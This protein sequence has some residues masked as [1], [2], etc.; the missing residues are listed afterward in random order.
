MRQVKLLG[1]QSLSQAV[2]QPVSQSVC[3]LV[4]QAVSQSV[5]LSVSQ[6][7]S[8][9]LVISC[10]LLD[11]DRLRRDLS[12]FVYN[13]IFNGACIKQERM[14]DSPQVT[15]NRLAN[16][17][18]KVSV[19]EPQLACKESAEWMW[20]FDEQMSLRYS[21]EYPELEGFLPKQEDRPANTMKNRDEDS[22]PG[23]VTTNKDEVNDTA[24]STV[25]R[26]KK[27]LPRKLQRT[28][29]LSVTG[30]SVVTVE[31]RIE[32]PNTDQVDEPPSQSQD[33]CHGED[34][35]EPWAS[36]S[37]AAT[38]IASPVV[39][40]SIVEAD[41]TSS[42]SDRDQNSVL[43][44]FRTA[45]GLAVT[46]QDVS[47]LPSKESDAEIS[48]ADDTS[49]RPENTLNAL[50][51]MCSKAEGSWGD[52]SYV[53]WSHQEREMLSTLSS[54][55]Q[56]PPSG[57]FAQA[58]L[59]S[60]CNS[61]SSQDEQ[62]SETPR[63]S[64]SADL[65]VQLSGADDGSVVTRVSEVEARTHT[66][67]PPMSSTT[68]E[69]VTSFARHSSTSLSVTTATFTAASGSSKML[70]KNFLSDKGPTTTDR[71]PTNSTAAASGNVSAKT[72]LPVDSISNHTNKF[73]GGQLPGNKHTA[74]R[75]IVPAPNQSLDSVITTPA[76]NAS[77]E[78]GYYNDTTPYPII[79]DTFSMTENIPSALAQQG[80]SEIRYSDSH[81]TPSRNTPPPQVNLAYYASPNPYQ[82][83]QTGHSGFI[84]LDSTVA[85]Q[86]ISLEK[87]Y[88]FSLP[89]YQDYE[90]CR[91]RFYGSRY[92]KTT[93]TN[94]SRLSLEPLCS[95]IYPL[96]SCTRQSVNTSVN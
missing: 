80:S 87:F 50:I 42:S 55:D 60:S 8:Q 77:L 48:L 16:Q 12:F 74:Y 82:T 39:T 68:S 75:P 14:A 88:S 46:N 40:S 91:S 44:R 4:S 32:M 41:K 84:S 64:D 25:N 19:C 78:S 31:E 76:T 1:S 5:C 3:Q 54:L 7:I 90:T 36:C 11:L 57:H 96:T 79:V 22:N 33:K 72:P 6:S 93:R 59:T 27:Y 17:T 35:I 92:Y 29:D 28:S 85:V 95:V 73:S 13:P 69:H 10:F 26:R 24:K 2:S 52:R 62:R 49:S 65:A 30:T 67:L 20:G 71:P 89:K 83:G 86:A 47:H 66:S 53:P 23:D 18:M 51:Q 43:S 70:L 34:K 37:D 63:T 15:E 21:P 9:V 45:A 81:F 56:L 61:L 38:P 58:S 94:F